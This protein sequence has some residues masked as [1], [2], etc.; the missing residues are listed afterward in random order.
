MSRS[1]PR[2]FLTSTSSTEP[3][4]DREVD[5]ADCVGE[6]MGD[7]DTEFADDDGTESV[8]TVLLRTGFCGRAVVA[9][10]T[11]ERAAFWIAMAIQMWVGLVQAPDGHT[12]RRKERLMGGGAACGGLL[13]S[14]SLVG[15]GE[16][17]K[18]ERANAAR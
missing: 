4:E 12:K 16:Y 15:K 11:V 17:F 2:V 3:S 8:V 10:L 18:E 7:T 13:R 14:G 1:V 6:S 5:D 9:M